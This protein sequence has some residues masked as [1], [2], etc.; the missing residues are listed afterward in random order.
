MYCCEHHQAQ[1][2]VLVLDQFIGFELTSMFK[3]WVVHEHKTN[4]FFE[5]LWVS[6]IMNALKILV[7]LINLFQEYFR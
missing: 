2:G 3:K 5:V 7:K 1:R 6:I 4:D